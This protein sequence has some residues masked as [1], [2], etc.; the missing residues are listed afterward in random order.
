MS[1]ENVGERTK[2][3]SRGPVSRLAVGLALAGSIL[4]SSASASAQDSHTNK[5]P[6]PGAD[7]L[8]QGSH[9]AEWALTLAPTYVN[10]ADAQAGQGPYLRKG[11]KVIVDCAVNGPAGVIRSNG[12]NTWWYHIEQPEHGYGGYFVPADAMRSKTDKG[13]RKFWPVVDPSVPNCPAPETTTTTATTT[14]T[15]PPQTQYPS[16]ETQAS[17]L[18]FSNYINASGTG[19]RLPANT[20][21]KVKCFEV[22]PGSAA[23]SAA[24]DPQFPG[25]AT[26]YVLADP[27]YAKYPYVASNTFMNG[28]PSSTLAVN[29]DVPMCADSLYK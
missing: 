22:G 27:Q 24:T 25:K 8:L 23:P 1:I 7:V 20:W 11:A 21:F 18:T 9:H 2:K 26:W 29:T 13:P 15:Q 12:K 17:P 28:G 4:A 16:E 19:P 3:V 6:A 5:Y 10:P 14:N